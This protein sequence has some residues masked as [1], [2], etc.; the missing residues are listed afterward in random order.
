[1]YSTFHLQSR[2]LQIGNLESTLETVF[3][4]F[5]S[6]LPSIP[7][8]S[9]A[10]TTTTSTCTSTTSL[11]SNHCFRANLQA[12]A[13]HRRTVPK[14]IVIDEEASPSSAPDLPESMVV[15]EVGCALVRAEGGAAQVSPSP[16]ARNALRTSHYA[17][18]AHVQEDMQSGVW[19]YSGSQ[20]HNLICKTFAA[21]PALS[22]LPSTPGEWATPETKMYDL[23][24]RALFTVEA[25]TAVAEL[26][27]ARAAEEAADEAE[28]V[29]ARAPEEAEEE[30]EEQEA[31]E[32]EADEVIE[33]EEME[34]SSEEDI[35]YGWI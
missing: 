32:V 19:Q 35:K 29:T 31:V 5:E 2:I 1:M 18:T 13:G 15:D 26:V 23:I 17:Q 3:K 8:T 30:A 6:N 11:L 27:T 14:V 9:T 16:S 10:T 24:Q 4:N 34:E 22:P 25:N 28:A 7:A 12:P 21:P 33:V 20:L